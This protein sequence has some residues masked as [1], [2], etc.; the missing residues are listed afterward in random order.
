[1]YWLLYYG[2]GYYWITYRPLVDDFLML[3]HRHLVDSL[4]DRKRYRYAGPA[5]LLRLVWRAIPKPDLI[6]VLDA[7][8]EV[9]RTEAGVTPRRTGTPAARPTGLWPRRYPTRTSSM[10]PGRST[11]WSWPSTR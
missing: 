6:V 8:A 9:V 7:P 3:G 1:M 2:L 10:P 4:V 11:R 5:W